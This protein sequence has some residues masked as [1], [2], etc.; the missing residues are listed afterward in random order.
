[1]ISTPGTI[2]LDNINHRP[3]DEEE[4][5]RIAEAMK[6]YS[7]NGIECTSVVYTGRGVQI[8]FAI[9]P[10][11]HVFHYR[12]VYDRLSARLADSVYRYL[13]VDHSFILSRPDPMGINGLCRLPGSFNTVSYTYVKV[14]YVNENHFNQEN[15]PTLQDMIDAFKMKEPA[16]RGGK[17]SRKEKG[18][19]TSLRDKMPTVYSEKLFER[20]FD[21]YM[22][23]AIAGEIHVGNRN[24]NI[25]AFSYNAYIHLGLSKEMIQKVRKAA[26]DINNALF[27]PLD[28]DEMNIILYH[29]EIYAEEKQ[30][31]HSLMSQFSWT[32]VDASIIGSNAFRMSDEEYR[33][34]KKKSAQRYNRAKK[35]ARRTAK[36]NLMVKVYDSWKSVKSIKAVAKLFNMSRTTIRKYIRI[37]AAELK[38]R[39]DEWMENL[40][41]VQE[42]DEENIS[43]LLHTVEA[44]GYMTA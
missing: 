24:M 29:A 38:A 44:E 43:S 41:A 35:M 2:E 19:H 34:A 6:G 25:Y 10:E 16:V 23:L 7:L 8:H 1:M 13:T 9:Q 15:R 14:M 36:H 37:W 31:G 22:K 28:E 40:N 42:P 27:E 39:H 17:K 4:A 11:K 12:S 5:K 18:K 20:A 30:R 21:S 3:M 32:G 26:H 33:A